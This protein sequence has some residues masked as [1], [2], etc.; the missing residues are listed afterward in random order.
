MR[1]VIITGANGFIGTWLV[2][3][4]VQEGHNVIAVIKDEQEKIIEI[5]NIEGVTIVYC[6]MK[7]I[8]QLKSMVEDM[9]ID[10][11]YHLAWIGTSGELRANYE[12]QLLNAKYTCDAVHAAYDIGCKRFVG[13]GSLAEY[14]C[15]NYSPLDGATPNVT[16]NYAVAKIAAEYMSKAECSKLGIEH[17]WGIFS[18]IYGVG[19]KTNNFVNFASKL[20]LEGK[21]ASFTDG[22]QNY[23]FVY[24]SDFIEGLYL[25]GKYGKTNYSYFIGSGKS[26]T[27]KEYIIA[28]RDAISD[29]I[30][31]FFGEIPFNGVSLNKEQLSCDKLMKDTGYMPKIDFEEGIKMTVGWLRNDN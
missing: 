7:N 30:E 8:S 14:D 16:A 20:M 4:M 10:T 29:D 9:E 13:A 19:N 17:V 24:I 22:M 25:L 11:F 5:E 28:I 23:D 26:R 31:L 18:N 2:K 27:M 12:L 6:D 21:R 3:K 15:L 1:T